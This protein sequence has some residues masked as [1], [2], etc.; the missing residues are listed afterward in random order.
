MGDLVEKV[1]DREFHRSMQETGL[2]DRE[3]NQNRCTRRV[4]NAI[5]NDKPTLIVRLIA[6]PLLV[7]GLAGSQSG[8]E[9]G[10]QQAASNYQKSSGSHQLQPVGGN[11]S[12]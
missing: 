2:Q 8:L 4:G 5:S 7:V 12:G 6:I 10:H 9:H 3:L 11:H 1:S